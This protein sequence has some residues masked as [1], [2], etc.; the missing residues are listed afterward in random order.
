[1][2]IDDEG[3][4][5]ASPHPAHDGGRQLSATRLA[6]RPREARH[7]VRAARAGCAEIWRVAPEPSRQAQDDAT[8]VA[9]RDMERAGID[10]IT[11]GEIRRESYSNRFATAL[12]GI[13][14]DNPGIVTLPSG[15]RASC[16]ASSARSAGR[17]PVEVRD[18]E[19]LRRNTD[20]RIKITLPGP[21][22]IAQQCHERILR[23]TTKRWRW[24]SRPRLM[25]RRRTCKAAG[26]DVHPDR[27]ALAAGATRRP[28]RAT[29]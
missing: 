4:S 22:T 24:T 1:M 9:I 10:I 8:L 13:D 6:R 5:R 26:A 28:R 18:V 17:G 12:E 16:R 15:Q 14:I 29:A 19:F 3:T 21:F 23:A 27:R 20:R 25:R 7:A 2:T 11:D